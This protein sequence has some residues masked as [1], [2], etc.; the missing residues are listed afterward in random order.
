MFHSNPKG[1]TYQPKRADTFIMQHFITLA[2]ISLPIYP[3]TTQSHCLMV[4]GMD[5]VSSTLY[6]N[7][8]N[9]CQQ[10]LLKTFPDLKGG[11]GSLSMTF[12]VKFAYT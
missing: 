12:R 5:G 8:L 7:C 6:D 3:A 10:E 9:T 2:Y 1:L 4:I 11:W